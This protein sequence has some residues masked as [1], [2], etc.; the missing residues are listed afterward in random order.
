MTLEL[1]RTATSDLI[2]QTPVPV[3]PNLIAS[4]SQ[5]VRGILI[6]VPKIVAEMHLLE[7]VRIMMAFRP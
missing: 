1:Y 5:D 3:F 6:P 4:R 2:S 7:Q